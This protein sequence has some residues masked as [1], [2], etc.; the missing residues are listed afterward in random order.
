MQI[1][2]RCLSVMAA[3]FLA[4]LCHSFELNVVVL[5]QD[6]TPVTDAV[7]EINQRPLQ[8]P[9]A[10]NAVIDQVD[11]R[12]VPMVIAVAEGQSVEF[13]NSDNVRHHVYSFSEIRQFSTE[14]FADE[15]IDPVQFNRAG[16]AVLGCNIHDSMVAYVYVSGWQDIAV[17]DKTGKL[18]F[19]GLPDKPGAISIW[20]PWMDAP[21]NRMEVSVAHLDTGDNI[22]VALPLVRPDQAFGFR[23]LSRDP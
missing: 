11:R 7:I 15:A 10:H 19:A 9:P 18:T 23:A 5:D 14:L 12:F 2:P 20:H 16:I 6:G 21:D 1:A 8:S 3:M 13:L 22:T 17:T 4:S